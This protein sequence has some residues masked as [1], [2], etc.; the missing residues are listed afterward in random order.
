[1]F[2][3]YSVLHKDIFLTF[4]MIPD[5]LTPA[6]SLSFHQR[7]LLIFFVTLFCICYNQGS[8]KKRVLLRF[9]STNEAVRRI[10]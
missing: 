7:I 9:C 2:H 5:E 10:L 6:I 1:M 4:Y 3:L 8:G